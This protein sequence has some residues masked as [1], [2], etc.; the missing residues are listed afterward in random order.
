LGI[1]RIL[2]AI[3]VDLFWRR[4]TL[5]L[6]WTMESF[7]V[8][9]AEAR[10]GLAEGGIPIGS[11]LE[12]SGKLIASGRNRR[13]Q[14]GD[15]IAHGEMSCLRTAGRQRTYRDTVLYTTLAPCAMCSGTII[16]FKI[17]LVIVGESRTFPGELELLRSRGV[18]IVEL[19]DPRCMDLMIEFQ[20]LYPRVWAEDVGEE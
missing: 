18:E 10:A 6:K 7:E 2:A 15:P 3:F 8:A 4:R 9:L 12:K 16:Q 11:A 14:D 1:L 20:E 5:V 19:N 13:V 17:P